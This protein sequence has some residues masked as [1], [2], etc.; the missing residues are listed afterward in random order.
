MTTLAK[1]LVQKIMAELADVVM[2]GDPDQR[3]PGEVAS[4]VM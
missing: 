4:D 3:Y 1:R 2:N